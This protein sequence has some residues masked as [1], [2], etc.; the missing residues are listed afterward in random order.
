[1]NRL[2][3]YL[4]TQFSTEGLSLFFTAVFLVCITQA[5]RLFDVVTAKGQAFL[6][7]IWQSILT[8]PP[9][10]GQILYI[11]LGIGIART[12]RAM[13]TSKEL[14][15]IHASRRIEGL[16]AG[17]VIF[18]LLGALAV[19]LV[20]HWIEPLSKTAFRLSQEQVAADLVGR[21]LSPNRFVQVSPGLVV[22]IGGRGSDGSVTDF[23]AHDARD[24]DSVRTYMA[25]QALISSDDDGFY[26]DLGKGK[27]QIDRNGEFTEV[28]F[29]SYQIAMDR[30]TEASDEQG[31]DDELTSFNLIGR[32]IT[33]VALTANQW[34]IFW[35]RISESVRSLV[36]CF[37]VGALTAFP[38]AR[39]RGDRIP[40]EATVIIVGLADRAFSQAVENGPLGPFAG[41]LI[42]LVISVVIFA[43]KYSGGHLPRFRRAAA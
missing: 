4:V 29:A 41:P 39:R 1:M 19:A 6:T 35:V 14:H 37:F 26:I 23:F 30:L 32:M 42:L 21:T 43:F 16:W 9:L 5:L 15:S 27:L 13:Q 20:V 38:H 3:R 33:G 25:D 7:L 17:I 22:E 24:P 10:S 18:S 36:T 40:L 34:H 28:G 11:C 12:L 8:T 2:P 31:H